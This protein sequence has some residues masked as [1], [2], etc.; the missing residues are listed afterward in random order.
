MAVPHVESAEDVEIIRELIG[1]RPVKVL[2]KIQNRLALQNL[3]SIINKSDGIIIGRGVLNMNL[4]AANMVYVQDYIIQKCKLANKPV[5]IS[6]QIM[7]SMVNNP[8]PTRSE[9][10][11]VSLAVMQG[12][13]G[14]I[15]SDETA[16]GEF[17]SEALQTMGQICRESEKHINH[18]RNYNSIEEYNP[19]S[20]PWV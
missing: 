15:L 14:L 5:M 3:R 18:F 19:E 9:V 16:C 8:M 10:S 17:Y 1:S 11:D 6:S 20:Y 4:T 13:D 12:V 2:A 7:G